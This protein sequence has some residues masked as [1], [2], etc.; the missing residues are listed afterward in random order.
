VILDAAGT[1]QTHEILRVEGEWTTFRDFEVTDSRLTRTDPVPGAFEVRGDNLKFINLV[2]HDYGQGFVA[3]RFAENAEF[4]GNII[5]YHGALTRQH[6]IYPQN[7]LPGIK[8]FVDNIIFSNAGYGIHAYGVRGSLDGFYL[9][10]NVMFNNGIMQGEE[11][12]KTQVLVGGSRPAERVT[13]VRNYTYHTP[14]YGGVN[15]ALGWAV[16]GNKTAIVTENYLVGGDVIVNLNKSWDNVLLQ[17]NLIYGRTF[18]TSLPPGLEPRGYDWDQNEYFGSRSTPFRFQGKELTFAE[19]QSVTGLDRNSRFSATQPRG[20]RVFLRSNHYD[21]GRAHIIVYNWDLKPSIDVDVSAILR[22]GDYYEVRDVQNYFGPPVAS[23]M[24][25][26]EPI[27]LPLNLTR[28]AQPVGL[29][30]QIKHTAPEFAVFVL[31][32]RRTF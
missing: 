13:L 3:S 5:Y 27:R 4:Y 20:V 11:V 12:R 26:G 32:S 15:I 24:Y 29:R 25:G 23:G 7:E 10:G 1:S 31:T 18:L 22:V 30:A 28:V 9:E 2:V 19:W 14:S 21:P 6:G 16:D 17:R 8:R